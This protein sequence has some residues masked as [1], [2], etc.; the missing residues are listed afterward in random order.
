MPENTCGEFDE[1]LIP[2]VA[3]SICFKI[4]AY[5]IFRCYMN[6]YSQLQHEVSLLTAA[7]SNGVTNGLWAVS[8]VPAHEIRTNSGPVT[9]AVALQIT[10]R[11]FNYLPQARLYFNK[12][13]DSPF[14]V[15]DTP[16]VPL[17]FVIEVNGT[18]YHT[19]SG[20]GLSATNEI[21]GR[22]AF[23]R[24]LAA[25]YGKNGGGGKRVAI[26]INM[27]PRNRLDTQNLLNEINI[28][29]MI[30]HPNL[31]RTYQVGKTYN[32]N[33]ILVTD[34]ARGVEGFCLAD[35][36]SLNKKQIMQ[37]ARVQW[38]PMRCLLCARH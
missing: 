36:R 15:F 35:G 26:K 18:R 13:L 16:D 17:S 38:M 12:K 37:I 5:D 2:F 32:G 30:D 21:N 4:V 29:R 10:Y 8:A 31:I 1:L 3:M 34:L 28:T 22:G 25:K 24:V 7:T 33:I 9:V 19:I 14:D 23:S 6:L 20:F 27:P 11:T